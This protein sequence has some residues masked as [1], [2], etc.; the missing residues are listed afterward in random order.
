MSLEVHGDWVDRLQ[1]ENILNMSLLKLAD[2]PV[3]RQCQYCLRFLYDGGLIAEL[4]KGLD[5]L[6]GRTEMGVSVHR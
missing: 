1:D 4:P 5:L 2:P 6:V 3:D